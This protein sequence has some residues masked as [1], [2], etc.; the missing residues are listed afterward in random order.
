MGEVVRGPASWHVSVVSR[1]AMLNPPLVWWC[2]G[3]AAVALG[4]AIAVS[5]LPRGRP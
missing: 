1:A 5:M 2:F 3:V 4:V